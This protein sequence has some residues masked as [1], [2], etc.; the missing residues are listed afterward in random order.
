MSKIIEVK[1]LTKS[2]KLFHSN[3]D[4]LI[5]IIPF[6]NKKFDV[7]TSLNNI[8]FDVKKG[9]FVSIIGKNGSGKST[10]LKILCGVLQKTSGEYI[11]NGSIVSL[12]ELGTGFNPEL[13][14]RDNII[15]S[16][17]TMNFDINYIYSKMSEIE[18]FA[19]LEEYFDMPIK[20]YSSGMYVRLAMSLFLHLNPDIFIIDE[21]LSVGDIFF[22]QKCFSKI[23][24]MRKNGVA[25]LFVS[26]DINTVLNMSDRVLLL[27]H[28][29][30]IY[31]GDKHEACKLYYNSDTKTKHKKVVQ[32]DIS[33][34]LETVFKDDALLSK[35]YKNNIFDFNKFND[36]KEGLIQACMIE[37]ENGKL[38]TSVDLMKSLTFYYIVDIKQTVLNPGLTLI[39][40]DRYSTVISSIN[41]EINQG[42]QLV[43]LSIIFSVKPD[44][45]TIDIRLGNKIELNRGENIVD[46][47]G[48]NT[49]DVNFDFQKQKAPF[50][51]VTYLENDVEIKGIEK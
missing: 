44:Q 15:V 31:F 9:E 1:N 23:E 12:L 48:V 32:D 11:V 4:R 17:K 35:I 3:K 37:D 25:F 43:K 51:G 47:V 16:S 36:N 2:F 7:H 38:T 27:D 19:D 8:S 10:L 34:T 26:H 6:I 14:G 49:I 18:A 28:S 45:Y 40:K 50:Y 20:T 41:K 29:K 39:V 46:Y 22:Q 24:E 30:Q 33:K 13:S 42:M 21:A 5:N